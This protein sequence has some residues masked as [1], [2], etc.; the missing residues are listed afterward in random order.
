MGDDIRRIA[1]ADI[2]AEIERL[3]EE[4]PRVLGTP[5]DFG[6]MPCR[7]PV[8][9]WLRPMVERLAAFHNSGKNVCDDID[10]DG[11]LHA[12]SADDLR[13]LCLAKNVKP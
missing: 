5:N 2:D 10:G 3:A 11:D 13:A 8:R 12:G 6:W 9:A 7:K 4:L 1:Q